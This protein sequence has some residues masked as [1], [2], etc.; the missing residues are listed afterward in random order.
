MIS[1]NSNSKDKMPCN[2]SNCIRSET[3]GSTIRQLIDNY[4]FDL[5]M[6]SNFIYIIESESKQLSG[7]YNIYT[8]IMNFIRDAN[9][10]YPNYKF[11][12]KTTM[13]DIYD[14]AKI[15]KSRIHSTS[16]KKY[17]LG[18]TSSEFFNL[19]SISPS[20]LIKIK[21][22]ES[23]YISKIMPLSYPHHYNSIPDIDSKSLQKFFSVYVDSPQFALFVKEAWIYC[24]I[25][26][27]VTI[28]TPTFACISD[29]YVT[30]GWPVTDLEKIRQQ[31]ATYVKKLDSDNI[32]II[33][34]RWFR[35]ILRKDSDNNTEN[36][37]RMKFGCI[38]MQ[39]VEGTL[40]QLLNTAA[41]FNLGM[42][43][44]YLYTKIVASHIANIILTDDH[45]G[46]IG[47]VNTTFGRT[48][49]IK[50]NNVLHTFHVKPGLMLQFIDLE[51][52]VF[53]FSDQPVY[54]NRQLKKIAMSMN[55]RTAL[56]Y[57]QNNYIFD[58]TIQAFLKKNV[59]R[60]GIFASEEEYMISISILK[61]SHIYNYKTFAETIHKLL[62]SVYT[63]IPDSTVYVTNTYYIDLDDLTIRKNI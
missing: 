44:E 2:T 51:R 62:P 6:Y 5:Q 63:T 32:S 28:Y 25:K 42:I 19:G 55:S 59:F 48:Y 12:T 4:Y 22:N 41:S 24:F 54:T 11:L 17:N 26:K 7:S 29:I 60:K 39:Q 21:R 15:F 13:T 38:E 43:F 49:T 14:M 33:N 52:Y 58:K 50:S 34:K 30:R 40:D 35:S 3:I 37:I 46:N 53:N 56:A 45:M 1:V 23:T 18:I 9:I 47:Y 10:K 8:K 61:S 16:V 57:L 27:Y 36:I 20:I 31:F